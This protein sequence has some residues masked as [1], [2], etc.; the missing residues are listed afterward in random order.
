MSEAF[1][2][3]REVATIDAIRERCLHWKE[4]KLGR[5]IVAGS[6]YN[7]LFLRHISVRVTRSFLRTGIRANH[8]TVFMMIAGL[9]GIAFAIPHWMVATI[10]AAVAYFL[11][12]LF[13][14]VD[15]EIARWHGTSST[16]G[17]YLD[18]VVHLLVGYPSLGVPALH[19]YGLHQ[20]DLYLVLAGVAITCGLMGYTLR[21][22]FFRINAEAGTGQPNTTASMNSVE[23]RP[24]SPFLKICTW[25][26]SGPLTSFP[27][28]K[29]RIV[30]ILT[31]VAI[32]AA[33][34]HVE[35]PLVC[36]A[37][38]YAVYCAVRLVLEIPYF[39]FRRVVDVPHAKQVHDYRW[40]I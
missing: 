16:R 18:K 11:F 37:W 27:I 3:L 31:I 24:R 20:Q 23:P 39:Y 38:F 7:R 9:A 14:A 10:A 19:Y 4:D 1:E 13:D 12:D 17:L 26:R 28:T 8:A 21:E 30:H 6:A 32:A 15:G 34:R 40:P 2:E 29:A 36:L 35:S 22:I 25:L 33:Y 5:R